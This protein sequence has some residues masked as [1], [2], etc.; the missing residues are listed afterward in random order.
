MY[1]P[2]ERYSDDE[3]FDEYPDG[4]TCECGEQILPGERYC[5]YCLR[6]KKRHIDED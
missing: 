3:G 5:P 4:H 6:D 2:R 1:D